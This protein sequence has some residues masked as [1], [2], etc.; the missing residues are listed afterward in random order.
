MQFR[1]EV[2]ST[3]RGGHAVLVPAELAAGFSTRRAAVVAEVDGVVVH[4]RLAVYGGRCYLGLRV[5][6]L[7]QL[8]VAAGDEVTV[9][10]Q[11]DPRLVEAPAAGRDAAPPAELL[12]ALAADPEARSR[13]EAMPQPDRAEY[14]AWVARAD[15][16]GTRRERVE[17]TMQRL[18]RA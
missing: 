17:R 8:G 5:A 15:D 10:L 18:R 9:H 7:R 12:E 1:A 14:A 3:G 16:V 6:L 2:L 4:S 13:Y 11:E